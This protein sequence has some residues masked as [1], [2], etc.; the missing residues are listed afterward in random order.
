MTVPPSQ[1]P[2]RWPDA[3]R[4]T[5]ADAVVFA[6]PAAVPPLVVDLG[7]ERR[8][9]STA[10]LGGGLTVARTWLCATVGNDYAR[11][12]PAE[13]LRERAAE[14]RLP[15]PVVGM[16]TGVDVRRVERHVRGRAGVHA[17]VGVGRGV[18]AAG[19]R[20]PNWGPSG[21]IN[22][23]VEVGAPLDD[24]AL[25]GA[26]QTA[27][28]A[29]AQALA[30]ARIPARNHAGPATGTPTDAVAIAVPTGGGVP[31]AGTATAIGAEIARAVHAAVLAGALADRVD[32]REARRRLSP[33]PPPRPAARVPRPG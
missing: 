2:A 24:G 27:V 20:P 12:D 28:E 30:D 15:G 23:L 32:H 16:L 21:T 17:T 1:S 11:L 25:V 7:G 29:K 3:R 5:A 4:V 10:V 33:P 18:A 6:D 19:T 9:L 22:L 14:L 31:F 26:L 13:D 8:V